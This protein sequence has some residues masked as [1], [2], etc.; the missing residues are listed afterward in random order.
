M[1]WQYDGSFEGFLTTCFRIFEA[2]DDFAQICRSDEVY[3]LNFN[4][5]SITQVPNQLDLAKRVWDGLE[6]MAGIEGTELLRDAFLH[7][8]EG[9]GDPLLGYVRLCVRYGDRAMKRLAEPVVRETERRA[10]AVRREAHRFQGFL[11]FRALS[12]VFSL[13]A[14]FKPDH[15]ILP[16][17][18]PHFADRLGQRDWMIHD[19]GRSKALVHQGGVLQFFEGVV[20][21]IDPLTS[22]EEQD[23]QELWQGFFRNISIPQ[24]R[25]SRLQKALLPKKYHHLLVEQP[26]SSS[27]TQS[28]LI[29][30]NRVFRE[31]AQIHTG[32]LSSF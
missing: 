24:R 29:E 6:R 2:K 18:A 32:F 28:N 11:R 3:E 13:Y 10:L 19:L 30:S 17:L 8:D 9:A 4:L 26:G 27:Q 23:F 20:L 15:D 16:L 12:E 31:T 22:V 21:E 14:D 1:I 7:R 25:N 5:T